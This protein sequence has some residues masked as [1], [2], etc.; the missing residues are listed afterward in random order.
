MS[1]DTTPSD[2]P[3]VFV[4][5]NDPQVQAK[6]SR[7]AGSM[8]LGFE[9]FD[10]G[11]EFLQ[12]YDASLPGCLVTEVRTPEIGGAEVQRT[13]VRRQSPLPLVFLTEHPMVPVIVQAMQLGAINFLEKPANEQ[14]LWESIQEAVQED[15]RRRQAMAKLRARGELMSLLEPVDRRML[16]LIGQGAAVHDIA[17]KVGVSTRTIETRRKRLMEKLNVGNYVELLRFA[18]EALDEAKRDTSTTSSGWGD[19]L[20]APFPRRPLTLFVSA[21]YE[22]DG[23]T[24]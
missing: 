5:D 15:K 11:Y 4:V 2:Q 3:T 20:A 1:D 19:G 6:I 7:L 16:E 9:A 8:R 13:L 21:R 22:E 14:H 17:D 12:T 10:T 23:A 24:W 18:F